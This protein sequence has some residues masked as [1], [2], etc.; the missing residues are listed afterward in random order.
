MIFCFCKDFRQ[1]LPIVPRR[2]H[3]QIVSACLKHSPLWHNVQRLPLI[4][5]MRLFS[6][7]MSP[8]ERYV[9][10]N[11][12]IVFLQLEKT[13]IPT[14]RSLANAIY[15]TLTDS[16]VSYRPLN[17]WLNTRFWRQEMIQSIIS[18]NNYLLP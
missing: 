5:N 11:L 10:R 8:D 14:M 1:I 16:N 13:A 15:P 4:I 9:N 3:G 2:I 18:M 6:P 12:Q 17:I 7:Q